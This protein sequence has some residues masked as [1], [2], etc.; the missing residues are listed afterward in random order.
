MHPI[1][2]IKNSIIILF[3]LAFSFSCKAQ[4]FWTETFGNSGINCATQGTSAGGFISGNGTWTMTN[5]GANG[6]TA[7]TWY[8]SSAEAGMGVGNCGD[9]CLNN[10][11]LINQTLHV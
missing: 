11:A 6:A 3:F 9:G 5:T 4:V 10:G 7:N 1:S 8:I 2:T